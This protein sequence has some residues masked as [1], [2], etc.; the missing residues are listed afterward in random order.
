[1]SAE[2][3]VKVHQIRIDFH[4]TEE[5]ERYV[6]V[7]LIEA[8]ACYLIDA[9]VAGSETQIAQ[10][11]RD[12]GR[13]VSEVRAIL[14]THAHPD[15]IGTAAWFRAYTGCTI[16]ASQGERPWI[17]D[18]DRQYRA[19]PIPNFYG[20]AGRSVPVDVAVRGGDTIPLEEGVTIEV[21]ATPGHS[22]DGVSYRLGDV[23]FLGDA[24]PVK[25]DIPI[26]IDRDATV[27]ALRTIG[28]LEGIRCYQPAWD[29]T[30][31]RAE[32]REKLADAMTVIRALD[33]QVQAVRAA[34]GPT[35][36]AALTE[37]VC[38]RL[39][40]PQLRAN[41]LFQRTVAAHLAAGED[42]TDG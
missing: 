18:I 29:R 31:S 23:L 25:G 5:I 1:M 20:L 36:H 28:A 15:H 21:I 6:F 7:Y 37:L 26:Y 17:E 16:Y 2:K 3:T 13:D 42:P 39:D 11:L 30:Y 12:I 35:D 8:D 38:R 27:R 9:G 14:L 10:Y 19:R 34:G 32:I 4:V 41:P 24:V 22:A 33:R 40:M